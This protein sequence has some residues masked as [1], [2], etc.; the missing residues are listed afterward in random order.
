MVR[1]KWYRNVFHTHNKG[2]SVIAKRFIITLKNKSHKYVT[3]V[4]QNAYIDKL[5][6]EINEYSNTYN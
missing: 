4:S 3:S 1:K 5:D 6:D 2:K